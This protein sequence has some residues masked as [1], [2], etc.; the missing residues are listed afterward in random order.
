M[1]AYDYQCPNGHRYEKREGFDAPPRQPCQVCGAEAKRILHPPPIVFK[2]SGFYITDSRKGSQ[3][4]IA[5]GPN[6]AS[7]PAPP[8]K[9]DDAK[10]AADSAPAPASESSST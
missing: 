6:S 3:A 2:G 10:P 8:A 7:V 4:T 1:P 9:K 5:D